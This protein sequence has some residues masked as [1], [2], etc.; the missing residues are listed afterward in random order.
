MV[1]IRGNVFDLEYKRVSWP[2]AAT[3]SEKYPCAPAS[4][5][6][7]IGLSRG[8]D[9]ILSKSE[10]GLRFYAQKCVYCHV[11]YCNTV[12]ERRFVLTFAHSLRYFIVHDYRINSCN[13]GLG[14][15]LVSAASHEDGYSRCR[16]SRP[17]TSL[18]CNHNDDDPEH[19]SMA[20][21]SEGRS[22]NEKIEL[23]HKSR[24]TEASSTPQNDS[25]SSIS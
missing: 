14:S 2:R 23:K 18:R 25:S 1:A 7:Q 17:I 11:Q 15:S 10:Q 20:L 4:Q 19:R 9:P 16:P 12:R 6:M 22:D 21:Y 5:R 8:K 24:S 3:G 13:M